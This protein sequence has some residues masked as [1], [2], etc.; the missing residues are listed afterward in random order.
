M[1]YQHAFYLAKFWMVDVSV[2]I[3]LHGWSANIRCASTRALEEVHC[4]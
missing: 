2:Y 3:I 4:H 1:K